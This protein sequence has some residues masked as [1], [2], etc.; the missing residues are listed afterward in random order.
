MQPGASSKD[1]IPATAVVLTKN[2]ELVI[3]DCV[4]ALGRFEQVIVFDS[5][6]TDATC[7]I[8]E[9]L[10]ATVVQFA[11]NGRYP[12]KKQWALEHPAV[13]H[14]WVVFVDADERPDSELIEHLSASLASLDARVAAI[15]AR[16]R[17][18]FMGTELRH[19]HQVIKRFCVNRRRAA[20][21]DLSD[22]Q[23]TNMWEVEG[24]YQPCVNGEVRMAAGALIH[25][26][27]DPIF[28]YFARHNRYSDWEA[29][30]R[31]DKALQAEVRP[32]RSGQGQIFD[33]LPFKPF[34]FF[35]YSYVLRSGWRD[36]RAGL[37]YALALSFYY[38][39]IEVKVRERSRSTT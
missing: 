7:T 12:K 33:R 29:Y 20:F 26:D 3:A 38:W 2:E 34:L 28:G 9:S 17:Y 4:R 39:Q 10:G 36:G 23:V 13:A 5:A 25:D 16:L 8:A 22:L 19:G 27:R 31:T 24:H 15:E 18:V 1:L 14:D 35:L 30:L 6:S 32:L 37:D 11:W 21:P